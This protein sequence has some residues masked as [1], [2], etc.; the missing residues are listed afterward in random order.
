M[1]PAIVWKVL[2]QFLPS[3]PPKNGA[4]LHPS[5]PPQSEGSTYTRADKG[6]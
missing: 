5:D 3:P 6:Y 2:G 1:I 4:G